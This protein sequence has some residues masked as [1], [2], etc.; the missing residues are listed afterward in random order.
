M[1]SR[2]D[3]RD[4][5]VHLRVNFQVLLS[6]IFLWAYLLSGGQLVPAFFLGYLA[7]HV[8]GYGGGT[9][10]NSCYDRDTGPIGGLEHPPPIPRG[11]LAF[12]LAWQAIGFGMALMVNPAFAAIYG[13]M[14]CLSVA[15][16][17][18]RIRLKGRPLAALFTVAVGQGVL[19]FLGGW[20]C[21]R[22]E[23]VSALGSPTAWLGAIG[24]TL[25]T[26]GFYPLTEVYQIVEDQQRGDLTL[27][28]WLGPAGSFRFALGALTLGGAA[29]VAVILMRYAAVEAIVL[30]L[31]LVGVLYAI[32]RWS[33]S[34]VLANVISNFRALMR[35]Y[36]ITSL[37][38]IAWTGLHLLGIL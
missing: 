36:A 38:F 19:G 34:F 15:Y 9:A 31:W 17:H 35:L 1:L 28:A 2:R 8:F 30:A 24:V 32:R 37:G 14:F 25:L 23:V 29:A 7:F 3:V 11:L 16:S 26:V 6:P 20:A 22:G 5:F 33:E 27:A 18:P 10:F 4:W 13:I 12:S 21:A